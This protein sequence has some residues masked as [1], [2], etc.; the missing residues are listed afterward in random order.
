MAQKFENVSA[1]V[2]G[3]TVYR[4]TTSFTN[5]ETEYAYLSS[6]SYAE[7]IIKHGD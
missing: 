5:S 6:Q 3:T 1:E 2:D 7:N 4:P